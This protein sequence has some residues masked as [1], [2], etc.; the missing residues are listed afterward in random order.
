MAIETQLKTK[1]FTKLNLDFQENL[2]I[3]SDKIKEQIKPYTDYNLIDFKDIFANTNPVNVEIGIGNG[4]FLVHYAS[5]FPEENFLGFEV[6]KRVIRKAISRA[7]KRELNNIKL[8]HYDGSFFVRLFPPESVKTFFINFPDPWPKKK[9]H[10]R[11]LMKTSFLRLLSEKMQTDGTL[12]IATDHENYAKE[13]MTNLITVDALRSCF[14]SVYVNELV[15]YYPTKY[16]RKFA[17][18]KGV[19]FFKLKKV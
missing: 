5:K 2:Y 15:D 14:E 1:D 12:Y 18:N 8:I 16:Y 10:K 7:Q 9:H 17:L 19:Y 3:F 4:E 6:V 11:R 13:I